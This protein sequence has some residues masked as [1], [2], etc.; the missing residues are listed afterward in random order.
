MQRLTVPNDVLL[1]DVE[2][3]L[4]EGTTVTLR[5]KGRSMLPFIVGGRDSVVLVKVRHLQEGDMVLARLAGGR[6][7]LHRIIRISGDAVTLMGDGNLQGTEQCRT[8]DICGKV[9][10][11]LR[12]GRYIE[13]DTPAE[14][15]KASLWRRLRPVRR[16]LLAVYRRINK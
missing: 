15:R 8:A 7:V 12:N 1:P 11:I 9:V 13:P 6:Y 5:V 3:L 14:R 10:K 4:D 2:R 16:Y